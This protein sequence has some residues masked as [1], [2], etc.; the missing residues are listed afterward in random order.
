M[1]CMLICHNET[2]FHKDCRVETEVFCQSFSGI[3]SYDFLDRIFS[4]TEE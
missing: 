1:L 2:C 3:D 4:G